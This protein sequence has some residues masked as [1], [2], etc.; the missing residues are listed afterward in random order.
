MNIINYIVGL[1]T[2]VMMPIIFL[3][4]GILFGVK[5]GKSFKAALCVG[6]GF[7]GLGLVID[8]LLENLGPAVTAM[9]NNLEVNLDV[10]DAGWPVASTVGWGSP[11][12]V[13]GV[14]AMLLVN[15]IMLVLKLTN[16]VDIDIFNYWLYLCLGAMVY[17]V[18]ESVS[19]SVIAMIILFAGSLKFADITADKIAES[20]GTKGISFPHIS[21]L[22]WIAFGMF[23]N[24]I[25]DKITFLRKIEV[26]PEKITSKFGVL[27]DS[28]VIGFILGAGIGLLARYDIGNI[29]DLAVKVAA[30]MIL[31]PKMVGILIEGLNVIKEAVELKLKEKFPNR[32]FYIGMDVAILAADTSVIA[33][34]LLMIPIT[35]LLSMLLPYNK[36]L[37]FVDL[38][39][40]LFLFTVVAAYCKK[41]ILRLL[42][43]GCLM[44]AFV[45][46]A[47]TNLA[48]IYSQAAV[49][50]QATFPA[51]MDT[52]SC[53]NTPFTNPIGW[54]IIKIAEIFY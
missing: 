12:M 24:Y 11:I 36:V 16:T 2:S 3:V 6:I 53:L 30:A 13:A 33:T 25:F 4:L 42:V 32:T 23:V 44:M 39:S 49:I 21:A 17:A 43:T 27:G 19:I 26:N 34:G 46:F 5:F 35:I 45:L 40:L 41:D 31:L 29:L 7:E 54:L 14:I 22:P 20:F 47:S 15:V 50:S 8:L 28:T 38:P 18:T 9:V 48:D 1:G 37:P 10:L 51:G 52:M